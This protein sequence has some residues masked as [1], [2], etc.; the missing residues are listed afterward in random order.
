M[1]P[2]SV[3]V[4]LLSPQPIKA[5]EI[6]RIETKKSFE[7]KEFFFILKT[8]FLG[9]HLYLNLAFLQSQMEAQ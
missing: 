6:A 9:C 8:P 5:K 1:V 4:G 7:K 2:G 3:V